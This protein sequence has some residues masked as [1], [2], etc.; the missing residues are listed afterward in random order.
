MFMPSVLVPMVFGR[1]FLNSG[2][3][4]TLVAPHPIPRCYQEHGIG[5]KVELTALASY[6][7]FSN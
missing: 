4:A 7:S 5:H 1:G 6:P 3:A 2:G